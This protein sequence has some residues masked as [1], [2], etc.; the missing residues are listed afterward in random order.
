MPATI[1]FAQKGFYQFVSEILSKLLLFLIISLGI[2]FHILG[3]NIGR[4]S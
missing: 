3:P 2:M 1:Y 4:V